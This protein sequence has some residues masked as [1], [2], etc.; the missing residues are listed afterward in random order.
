MIS[1]T[2]EAAAAAATRVVEQ[3]AIR[4]ATAGATEIQGVAGLPDTTTVA[5]LRRRRPI[6][7]Q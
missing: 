7:L 5:L 2:C 4:Q 1:K 3:M 6:R